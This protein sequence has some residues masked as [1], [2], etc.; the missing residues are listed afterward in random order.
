MGDDHLII[1]IC[2]GEQL[3]V[4]YLPF[5]PL[6]QLWE[7]INANDGAV[8]TDSKLLLYIRKVGEIN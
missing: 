2:W 4:V 6:P 1:I 5:L 7:I 3:D 8:L